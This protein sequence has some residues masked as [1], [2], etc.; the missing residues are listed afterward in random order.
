MSNKTVYP[1]IP[2]SAPEIKA[3]M[4][5]FVGAKD[6]MELYEEIP[7]HLKFKGLLNL[8]EAIT[9]EYSIKK[10]TERILNK[11]K[12]ASDCSCFLGAGC[13]YHYTPAVCDEIANRGEFVS[14]YGSGSYSDHGKHQAFF[15]C[16][17]MLCRLTGM[18]FTSQ[19]CHDGAQASATAICM[20][21]RIN[22]RKNILVPKSMNPQILSAMKNYSYSVQED[23]RL[24]IIGV[25]YDEKTGTLDIADLKAKLDDSVA[26]VFIENPNYFG[27]LEAEAREIGRLA[28]EAGAEYIVYADPIS[29]GVLEAPAEY[30][31]TICVG[32]LHSLGSH[33]LSGGAQAGFITTPDEMKYM[34]ETKDLAFGISDTIVEGEYGFTANL[35]ERTHYAIREKG[36]EFTGT[37]S[38]YLFHY[39]GVYMSL[40]GPQ[41]MKEVADTIMSNALYGAR[42]I[43]KLPGVKIRFSGVFFEE[44]IVDFNGTGKSVAEINKILL[45]NDIFGGLD[46]SESF[47]E[48]GQSSLYCITEAITKDEID[49]LVNV[50]KAA[51]Q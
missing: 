20:A 28:S 16:Q 39:A 43:E 17:T 34:E 2:N 15:E 14:S 51:L 29:L 11:N 19:T 48:L 13:A 27:L 4:L 35:Y 46:L 37:Q 36:V 47:P 40:M 21:N 45:D 26:A 25:D 18:E 22:G 9:D 41:G 44:F 5:D 50:L 38:N 42:L 32:D 10:H 31:A 12:S 33:L 23:K 49:A 24:N 30:G 7:D 3:Q 6:E 8:P 1:Y